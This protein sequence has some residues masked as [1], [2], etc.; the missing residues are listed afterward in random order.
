MGPK[1]VIYHEGLSGALSCFILLCWLP[2]LVNV[3]GCSLSPIEGHFFLGACMVLVLNGD[4][5]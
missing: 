2:L 3:H 5:L 4:A 1:V